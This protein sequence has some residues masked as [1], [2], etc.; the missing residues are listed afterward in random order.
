MAPTTLNQAMPPALAVPPDLAKHLLHQMMPELKVV[1]ASTPMDAKGL[2]DAPVERVTG[3]N[4]PMPYARNLE[5]AKTPSKDHIIPAVR[6]VC[7][8]N[9]G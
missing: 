2:L 7:S 6:R 4:A 8:E 5:R 9:E 3:A 1:R